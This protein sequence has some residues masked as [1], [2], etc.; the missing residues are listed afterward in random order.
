VNFSQFFRKFVDLVFSSFERNKERLSRIAPF[1]KSR[2]SKFSSFLSSL[3]SFG[4]LTRAAKMTNYLS[5]EIQRKAK[6]RNPAEIRV[7]DLLK[8]R[9]KITKK[10]MKIKKS[11]S[12][13]VEID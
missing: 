12:R 11:R 2:N 4:F 13:Q 8:S 6:T 7:S 10:K 1:Q 3:F 9:R 5:V